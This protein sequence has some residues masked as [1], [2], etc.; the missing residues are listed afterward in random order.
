[1][2]KLSPR[3]LDK[4]IM[5]R[6]IAI[7]GAGG[8]GSSIARGIQNS[9]IIK[10][11][12]VITREKSSFSKNEHKMFECYYD[13]TLAVKHSNI[14]IVAVQPKQLDNLIEEIKS[15]LT[16]KHL[17]ISIVSGVS[18]E[19]VESLIN[20]K[21]PIIR[22]MPNTAIKTGQS[23]TCLAFNKLGIKHQ[24]LV[25]K[26]FNSV[27]ITLL[28]SES[29]F[30]EATVLC[31]SGPALVLKFIRAY[32]QACIQHGFNDKEALIIAGQVTKGTSMIVQKNNYHPEPEID[33]VTTPSGCTIDALVE[34]E[35]RGFSSALLRSIDA[36]I[37]KAK[38]LYS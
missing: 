36:G 23:M 38:T 8:I 25:E 12:I 17:V 16:E 2:G 27:G 19:R 33:K 31:G 4:I 35:H 26:I 34:L 9:G 32:M 6:K 30:A 37:K 3:V 10:S 1:M 18:I 21:I 5:E 29:K 7:L 11:K 28:V 22:A 20:K 24:T 15:E 13:N 14:I